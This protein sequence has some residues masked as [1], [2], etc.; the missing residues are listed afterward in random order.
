MLREAKHFRLFP[1]E[2]S[3]RKRSEILLPRLLDQNDSYDATA[4]TP[5]DK[6]QNQ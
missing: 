2:G 3:L 6:S 1:L 4:S 5:N